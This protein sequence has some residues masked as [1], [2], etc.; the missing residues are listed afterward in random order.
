MLVLERKGSE[1]FCN[2]KKLTIVAQASKGANKE[3]VKIAGLEG[4][5]GQAWVSLTRLQEGINNVET[6]AREVV[7]AKK[8][9]LTE[10]ETAE[11][12]KLQAKID[13]IVETAKSRYVPN[14]S[15]RDLEKNTSL[16]KEQK[17]EYA[18]KLLAQ[19]QA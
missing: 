8:Y 19:L 16:T 14:L 11:V 6:K 18:Q 4:S 9:A 13:A 17:I 2:N 15:I 10:A 12:A 7:V 1:V 5:N 3:V